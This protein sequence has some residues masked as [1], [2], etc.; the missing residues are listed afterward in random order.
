[1]I[2]KTL[3]VRAM[4]LPCASR[5][6]DAGIVVGQVRAGAHGDQGALHQGRSPQFITAFGDPAAAFGLVGVLDSGHYPEISGQLALIGKTV[7][8]AASR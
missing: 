7:D 1:M 8:I 6:F 3:R 4:M 5:R 2:P